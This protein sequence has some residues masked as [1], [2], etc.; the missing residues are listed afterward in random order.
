VP[1]FGSRTEV[2]VSVEPAE[3]VAGEPVRVSASFGELDR[4]AQGARL[5]LG[6]RNT[7]REDDTDADGD[8]TTRTRTSDVLVAV[9]QV[10]VG[11]GASPGQLDAQL[12]VPADAPGT[13]AKSVE[14]FVRALVDRRHARDATAEQPLTVLA[15]A[16]ALGPWAQSAPKVDGR[17][18]F[19]LDVST[20]TVRPGDAITGTLTLTPHE[21]IAARAVRVQLERRRE[22]PD[23]NVD[24]DDTTRVELRGEGVL[25]P[26]EQVTLPFEIVVPEDAAPSFRAEHNRQRW[27]LQ[28]VVDV[29]RASDPSI[30]LEIVVHTA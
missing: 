5:E 29:K 3:V 14:W 15:P 8:R 11:D 24:S 6:Y 10:P 9:E 21:E 18:T 26:G 27:Y 12:T 22:D 2:E 23:R 13:A 19:A 16:D 7:Y 28:G 20:R 1:L 17:C 4:K 30:Q 25:A